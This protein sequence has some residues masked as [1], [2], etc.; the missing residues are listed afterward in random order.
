MA[1]ERCIPIPRR[2]RIRPEA[3]G[4][5]WTDILMAMGVQWRGNRLMAACTHYSGDDLDTKAIHPSQQKMTK[6]QHVGIRLMVAGTR[7]ADFDP[8]AET[9]F[10]LK[11]ARQMGK[12][13]I[14]A[15]TQWTDFSLIAV[16]Q[17]MV[18]L[19][20]VTEQ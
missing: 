20:V 6:R 4:T 15:S 3:M 18:M 17:R 5:R 10:Y 11:R 16:W 12:S 2:R 7:H 9:K 14:T 8:R 19:R 13:L 1:Q